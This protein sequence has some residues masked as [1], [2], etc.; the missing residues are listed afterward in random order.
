MEKSLS[1]GSQTFEQTFFNMILKG[2][3]TQEEALANCDSPTNLLW[4]INNTEAGSALKNQ[5][6]GAAEAAKN[7]TPPPPPPAAASGPLEFSDF[8]LNTAE[9]E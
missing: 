2:T 6:A 3:I 4:L 9:A 1:P 5:V 7:D 8:K